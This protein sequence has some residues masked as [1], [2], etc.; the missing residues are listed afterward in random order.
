MNFF[1]QHLENLVVQTLSHAIVWFTTYHDMCTVICLIM[2]FVTFAQTV[3][4]I[5]N[6]AVF[7]WVLLALI[8][9]KAY[10]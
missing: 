10:I 3:F 7:F 6:F 2:L 5:Q 8:L 4:F 9:L 1:L